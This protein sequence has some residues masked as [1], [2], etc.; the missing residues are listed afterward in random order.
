M[1]SGNISVTRRDFS[2]RVAKLFSAIGVAGIAVRSVDSA[3]AA[4]APAAWGLGSGAEV[5]HQERVFKA[6]RKRVYEALTDNNQF[7]QIV[8]LSGA[9]QGLP[10]GS[11]PNHVSASVGGDFLI[12]GGYI[13]GRIVELVPNER[14]VQAWRTATWKPGVFSIARFELAEQGADTKLV[15]DHTGFPQGLGNHLAPGWIE[16]Y[17]DPMEKF[18]A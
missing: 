7:D 13:S 4:D 17:W 1:E 2:F 8:R 11:P 5:I 15:F 12:F 6:S 10:A 9:M 18:L 16:H 14:I 3:H